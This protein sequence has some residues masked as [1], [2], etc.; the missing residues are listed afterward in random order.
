MACYS[1]DHWAAAV[2]FMQRIAVLK[3]LLPFL[4]FFS[5]GNRC[6]RI[7]T[8]CILLGSA[9]SRVG[10]CPRLQGGAAKMAEGLLEHPKVDFEPEGLL[11]H[12]KA[13]F[14]PEDLPEALEGPQELRGSVPLTNQIG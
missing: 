1:I 6:I 14:E 11:K 5:A 2:V 3:F 9:V 4:F 13:D 7:F 12:P 10:G 8:P